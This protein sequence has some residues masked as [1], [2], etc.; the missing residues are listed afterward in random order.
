MYTVEGKLD[1]LSGWGIRS[2]KSRATQRV[3]NLE[4][5]ALWHSANA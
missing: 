1:W 5:G 4:Y 2:S 3:S